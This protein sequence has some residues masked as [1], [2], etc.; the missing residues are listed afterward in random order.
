V[1]GILG[2]RRTMFPAE[3]LVWEKKVPSTL[4]CDP[5]A[6]HVVLENLLDNARKYGGGAVELVE[7][8][9]G[10]RWRLEVK[11][12][13]QGFA[14]GDTERLFEPFERGGGTGV[15]HGSGLGLFIARQLMRRM[16]GDLRAS[17]GGPGTG[18]TFVLE[19]P[20]SSLDPATQTEVAHG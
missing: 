15:A 17:S 20:L 6:I 11:D 7:S 16:D 13:G 9:L 3:A 18:A 1:G 19:L 14:P 2:H 12:K 4:R 5:D 10:T 8:Q